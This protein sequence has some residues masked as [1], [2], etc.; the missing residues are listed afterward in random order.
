[1]EGGHQIYLDNTNIR[2]DLWGDYLESAK[3]FGY[4]VR[5]LTPTN[6]LLFYEVRGKDRHDQQLA[7]VI[8]IRTRGSKII[9][10]NKIEEMEKLFTHT[11]SWILPNKSKCGTDPEKWLQASKSWAPPV[12]RRR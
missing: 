7:H 5:I 12:M 8:G 3:E 4:T 6:K 9:P 1:M 10:A 2:P 11:L